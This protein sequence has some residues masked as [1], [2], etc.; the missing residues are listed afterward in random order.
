ML[1][2]YISER[3][4]ENIRILNQTKKL[5]RGRSLPQTEVA[6]KQARWTSQ[7]TTK[8]VSWSGFHGPAKAKE[9]TGASQYV[10]NERIKKF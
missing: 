1:A 3:Q 10:P 6:L 7:D 5:L 4:A 2:F 8:W 9:K